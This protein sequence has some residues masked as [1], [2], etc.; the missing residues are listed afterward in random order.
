MAPFEAL[1]GRACRSPTLWDEVGESSV[2]GPQ[3]IQ[4]DA[5]LVGTIRRRM[6]EAQDRQKSYADR[7]RRPLEFSV[8]DH[9]FLRV[10][11]TK[12]IL[13]RIGEVAYR[14]ALPPSLAGVHDVFHVS[15]L[16]KYVPHPTHI[17]TDVSITLQPD[18]TYEE[19]PVRILDHKE[20]QLRN[21]TILLV[22]VGWGHHSDDEATW[23]L[24]DEIRARYPQLFDE[25]M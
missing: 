16:R 11:P 20:R 12:G 3:C 13:E 23:E 8:D 5:E 25:G 6:T 7:R 24:E 2:L 21:K 17:L 10:S 1:Y 15:M 14:L 18:V 4:R 22:K 9:V 19:V